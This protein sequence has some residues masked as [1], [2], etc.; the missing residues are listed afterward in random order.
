[1]LAA[2]RCMRKLCAMCGDN[3]HRKAQ[4]VVKNSEAMPL[5]ISLIQ[6]GKGDLIKAES[7]AALAY[8]CLENKDHI[9][10]ALDDFN[11]TYE[12]IF[13]LLNKVCYFQK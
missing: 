13:G 2:L 12:D 5:L 10:I 9:K 1:M 7:A 3:C 6:N 11:F 8:I 4:A